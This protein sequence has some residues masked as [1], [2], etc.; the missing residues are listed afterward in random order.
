MYSAYGTRGSAAG[1]RLLRAT[2]AL[3]LTLWNAVGGGGELSG[4]SAGARGNTV[5]SPA[6]DDGTA[7]IRHADKR[8]LSSR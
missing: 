3:P 4:G 2:S 6:R 5:A 7:L 8:A 1:C